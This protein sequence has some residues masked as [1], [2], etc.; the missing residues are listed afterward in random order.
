MPATPAQLRRPAAYAEAQRRRAGRPSAVV[1]DTDRITLA[2][3]EPIDRKG[4][5]G[6]TMSALGKLLD[7]APSAL[8]NHVAAKRDVLLLVQDHLTSQVDVTGFG[9]APWDK[10]VQT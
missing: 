5:S 4:Y 8:Y 1:L 7:V 2:A 9:T 3:L 10:A 6:F